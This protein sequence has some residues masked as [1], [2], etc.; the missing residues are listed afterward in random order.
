LTFQIEPNDKNKL[1][2]IFFGD[3]TIKIFERDYDS[4]SKEQREVLEKYFYNKKDLHVYERLFYLPEKKNI[5]E[6]DFLHLIS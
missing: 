6:E 3:T 5:I 4:L 1:K 2:E